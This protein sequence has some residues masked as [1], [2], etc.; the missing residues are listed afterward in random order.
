[1]NL[2]GK[3]TFSFE[4]LINN[5]TFDCWAVNKEMV[6]IYQ[7][8]KSIEN[9]GNVIGKS[10]DELDICNNTKSIWRKQ[11]E[12]VFNG[13][14]I[15]TEYAV[16]K[17]KKHF[18]S[19]IAP[20]KENICIGAIGATMDVTS[21][22]DNEKQ[23][24]KKKKELKRFNTA[25]HVILEKREKDKSD[26]EN[27]LVKTVQLELL[28]LIER[29]K[30]NNTCSNSIDIIE[31]LETK[32]RQ[33][34]LISSDNLNEILSHTELQVANLIREGKPSKIIA[35]ILNISKSTVDTHR[36]SIRRKLGLKNTN[37]S[38]KEIL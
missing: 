33:L 7:N 20:I 4:L 18:K 34:Q 8:D 5:F 38:L 26:L 30:K 9:W 27:N 11:L 36:D 28:P 23:L 12:Q 37:K 1:M 6:Y 15:S 35:D 19:I 3:N 13:E 24:I 25:L 16:E 31:V 2:S 21:Y 29:L 22:K 14:I 17:Q 32:L 10:I